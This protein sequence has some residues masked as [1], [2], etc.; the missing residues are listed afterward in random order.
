MLWLA[1]SLPDALVWVAPDT[2]GA[3]RLRLDDRPEPAWQAL[4]SSGMK[5]DRVED[6]AEDV[7][8]ALTIGGIAHANRAC[9][10]VAREVVPRRFGQLAATIDAVHD[11]QRTVVVGLDIGNELHELVRFPVKIEPVE[12]LEHKGCVTHPRVTVVP[13]ALSARCLWK[14][15][16]ESSDRRA[17]RHKGQTFDGER[18]ALNGGAVAVVGNAGASEPETPI[19]NRCFDSRLGLVGVPRCRESFCPGERTIRPLAPP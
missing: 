17:G 3:L 16:G 5:Q 10:C 1:A 6:G 7:V 14:G 11:L 2:A 9:T 15:R 8:L 19:A 4:I 13:V 18:R 12:R